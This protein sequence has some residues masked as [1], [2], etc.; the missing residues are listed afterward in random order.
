MS[1]TEQAKDILYK[2][3][4]HYVHNLFMANADVWTDENDW[5]MSLQ[6]F[7]QVYAEATS[8]PPQEHPLLHGLEEAAKAYVVSNQNAAQIF[9][10]FDNP[11]VKNAFIAGAQYQ[12]SKA[13]VSEGRGL[14]WVKASLENI[15]IDL[16]KYHWR[17]AQSKLPLSLKVVGLVI[18][19]NKHSAIEY[20]SEQP[21]N[22]Q[23][24][25]E[26]WVRAEDDEPEKSGY[27]Q[28]YD[29]NF[30]TGRSE[31]DKIRKMWYSSNSKLWEIMGDYFHPTHWRKLPTPPIK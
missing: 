11:E 14:R 4:P 27:Y 17:D 18:A 1:S 28:T 21:T 6:R 15:P 23:E 19:E 30:H 3:N 12:A 10:E 5:L 22:T 26:D 8:T 2:A 9:L 24:N 25:G 29:P 7:K 31:E 20:L 13:S 16:Y